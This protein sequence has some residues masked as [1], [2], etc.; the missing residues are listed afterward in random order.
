MLF[1]RAK[2]YFLP[3]CSIKMHLRHTALLASLIFMLASCSLPFSSIPATPTPA[4]TTGL[5]SPGPS[6]VPTLLASPPQRCPP[7]PLVAFKVFPKGWGGYNIDQKLTSHAPVWEDF[8]APNRPLHLE[9]GNTY[10][11]WPGK[12]VLWEVGPDYTQPVT[13]KVTNLRTREPTWWE[14]GL[15]APREWVLVQD[16][17]GDH[18]SPEPGWHEWA[19]SVFFFQAGCYVMDVSW[20]A[21]KSWPSGHWRIIFPVGR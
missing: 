8:I 11:P 12:K 10:N 20:P 16:Q 7:S 21:G 9:L 13:I 2:R 5:F 19:S 1:Q 15:G 4:S 14:T 6:P 18:G 17:P 3:S